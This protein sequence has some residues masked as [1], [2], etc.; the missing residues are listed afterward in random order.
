MLKDIR[1]HVE[2]DEEKQQE[3]ETLLAADIARTHT[4]NIQAFS[5]H[6]PSL[7]EYVQNV[8]S[9][10]ISLFCNKHKQ[11]NIVDYGNGRT[12]YGL[13]PESEV[14]RQ[15]ELFN[16]F[17][18]LITFTHQENDKPITKA[19]EQD[20]PEQSLEAQKNYQELISRKALPEKCDLVVVLGIGL[21]KHIDLLISQKQIKHLVIY[22][23]EI[24]Y[25]Q[26]SVLA[27]DWDYL[28]DKAKEKS[29]NIYLQLGK[30]GRDI[31]TDLKEFLAVYPVTEGYLYQHYHHPIFDSIVTS[32][33]LGWRYC[34][35]NGIQSKVENKNAYLPIWTQAIDLTQ[36]KTVCEESSTLYQA[37]I[38]AFEKYFPKIAKEFKSYQAKY[39]FAVENP[40]QQINLVEKQHLACLHGD[41][42]RDEGAL[43]FNNFATFPNKDGL[44]LGYKGTKLKHYSHYQ[45]VAKTEKL[46]EELEE[47]Q[48]ALP[49]TI[50]SLIMFGI[51]TGYQLEA[52]YDQHEVEKLF[53]CEPNRDYFYASLF[54]INWA[55]ILQNIDKSGARIYLNIGDDGTNLF[56][57]LLNQFYSIGPY[58][59]A[60]TY[61]YQAYYNS[62]LVQAVAQLREQLQV[63]ISM[64]EY[65]DHAKYGIAHTTE[66][67]S[68]GYP[69]LIKHPAKQ[70]TVQQK[71]VPVFLVGNGPSLDE[72]I[73]VI[74][75]WREQAIIVSCGTALMPLYKNG[76]VPD[77]HAEIEQNRST[78]DWICRIGD[79]EYLKKIS[80]I[81]CN[82]IHPDTCD[83][84]KDVYL[85][86]KEGESSTASAIEVIGKGVYEELQFAFPTVS[87]FSLNIFSKIGFN[88]IYLFGV[89]LGF[90]DD[91]K[92]HSKESGYYKDTGEEMYNYREKNNTSMV[93]PGNFRK[94]VFTKHE[95]KVSKVI[96]EQTLA[97]SKIDCFNCS[98][99][100]K[101]FGTT[102]LDKDMVLLTNSVSVKNEALESFKHKA[103]VAIE[104]AQ[105]YLEQFKNKF[106][107]KN[108]E[109]ELD[110]IMEQVSLPTLSF[111]DV[112]NLINQQKEMLFASYSHG[113]S[114]L[115]YLL[116]GTVNYCNALLSKCNSITDEKVFSNYILKIIQYWSEF[117][118]E[119]KV[120]I[121]V[122]C[123][124]FDLSASFLCEREKKLLKSW[125]GKTLYFTE[126]PFQHMFENFCEQFYAKDVVIPKYYEPDILDN[127][128]LG[129][130]KHIRFAFLVENQTQVDSIIANINKMPVNQANVF[131]LGDNV[132]EFSYS[133]LKYNSSILLQPSFLS[134]HSGKESFKRG[135]K[136]YWV[137][138]H[139]TY[140][141]LKY[142]FLCPFSR[143]VAP[144][145][146]S[147]QSEQ[148]DR[149]LIQYYERVK[150]ATEKYQYFIEYREYLVFADYNELVSRM[151]D[152]GGNRGVIHSKMELVPAMLFDSVI[153]EKSIE[154]ICETI[155][156]D[157]F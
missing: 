57:D 26:C 61:F 4:K 121:P 141:I 132:T 73:E 65:Y 143:Y 120:A 149:S 43:N 12:L 49:K 97:N 103:F 77:F 98:D 54:A 128:E 101:I 27:T 113:K 41:S 48:G 52:L 138:E 134:G 96:L 99:G 44:V 58:V 129:E 89:D 79:F 38:K 2:Q 111:S 72:S 137:K 14:T 59:L 6:I 17:P 66:T 68:R 56:K 31:I 21:A 117:L 133:K 87:N 35:D 8:R 11:K 55:E 150:A 32:F 107:D 37:N 104:N 40:K 71:E 23:P 9:S 85:S 3:I 102:P 33:Q 5:Y 155:D 116:Y 92:H 63:V 36:L 105:N 106:R 69:F 144:K 10:N 124:N 18:Q 123:D 1:L 15:F 136:L 19:D 151:I 29:T 46:L 70:L 45:F 126:I 88:Q 76:I 86:F 39:W 125:T 114:L 93:V 82:G 147:V 156:W 108:F 94:S 109:F 22:E 28:L 154:F 157:A 13:D 60:S 53:I 90:V 62:T 110:G 24:Q 115:F 67:I 74:K 142:D 145:I 139:L 119:V 122:A 146:Q 75:E 130:F 140:A 64:G 20:E 50:K 42:P 95:F 127:C 148:N 112:E 118:N 80:L 135:E 7:L 30:D 47:E 16:K 81:S 34:F 51:G 153:A 100:A 152:M 78:F 25:F 84:F 91:K 131:W 83:L